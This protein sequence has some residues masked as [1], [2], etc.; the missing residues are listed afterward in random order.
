MKMQILNRN[1]EIDEGELRHRTDL[2]RK[3]IQA[4]MSLTGANP[5]AYSPQERGDLYVFDSIWQR[6]K[7]VRFAR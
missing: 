2:V 4:T 5:I 7:K 6:I 3:E 1:A